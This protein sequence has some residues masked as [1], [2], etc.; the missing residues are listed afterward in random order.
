MLIRYVIIRTGQEFPLWAASRL[1]HSIEVQLPANNRF[2]HTVTW[3]LCQDAIDK[4]TSQG[5]E[6]GYKVEK[7]MKVKALRQSGVGFHAAEIHKKC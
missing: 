3:I 7:L 5:R 2:Q 4:V 6:P 1:T